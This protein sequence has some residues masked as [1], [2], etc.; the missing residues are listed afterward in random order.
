MSYVHK[1]PVN[2]SGPTKL[3]LFAR[4]LHV[5]VQGGQFYVWALFDNG[6]VWQDR[7]II[8]VGTG[9]RITETKGELAHINTFLAEGGTFVG[10]AFEVAAR[11]GEPER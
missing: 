11:T 1:Y 9:H 8:V 2:L 7:H 10:H 5:D 6:T 4:I 3:P